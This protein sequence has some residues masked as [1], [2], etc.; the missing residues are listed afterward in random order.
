VEDSSILFYRAVS[1]CYSDSENQEVS[2]NINRTGNKKNRGT[3]KCNST[4]EISPQ[5]M[6][7]IVKENII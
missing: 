1:F 2:M 4:A 7:L 6:R 3:F 5:Q